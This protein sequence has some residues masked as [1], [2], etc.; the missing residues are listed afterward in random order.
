MHQNDYLTVSIGETSLRHLG[1]D[2]LTRLGVHYS[3]V[4]RL[5]EVYV[6]LEDESR[7][8]QL[9]VLD[10]FADVQSEFDGETEI[11]IHLVS[12]GS[13]IFEDAQVRELA[14]LR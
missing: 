11:M 4:D 13:T 6:A 14:V 3:P 7:A 12:P 1:A 2:N 10:R 8:S 5:A 9:L